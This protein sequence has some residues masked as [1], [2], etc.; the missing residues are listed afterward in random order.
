[1]P[2]FHGSEI[3]ALDI[4]IRPKLAITGAKLRFSGLRSVKQSRESPELLHFFTVP[5]QRRIAGSP[6]VL[7]KLF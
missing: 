3:K 5:K 4:G 1:V 7:E 2:F 6:T